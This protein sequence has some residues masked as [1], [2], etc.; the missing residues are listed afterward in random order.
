MKIGIIY[1]SYAT[2]EYTKESISPWLNDDRFE[3][4]A[5]S[6]PFI[7]F[8][9]LDNENNLEILKEIQSE[10]SNFK[11]FNGEEQKKEIEARQIALDYLF[12]K[13]INAIWI[14]DSDEFYT[15]DQ[16]EECIK[17]VE[18]EKF[19]TL[20]Y[21]P[22]KNYFK[23]EEHFL[24]D[25]FIPPRIYRTNYSKY[26]L[27]QFYEDNDINY[28]SDGEI[29]NIGRIPSSKIPLSHPVKHYSW[30]DNERSKLKIQYQEQRWGGNLEGCSYK[31]GDNGIEINEKFYQE[32]GLAIPEILEQ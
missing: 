26:H 7:G 18:K 25:L 14:V 30:L 31:W 12:T 20:F 5:I 15:S 19:I 23:D 22:F 28:S 24:K 10:N 17:Y 3:I 8:P 29:L 1:C 11:L 16:I 6:Y 2:E 9:K 27:H 4:A 13:N 32:R 21:I